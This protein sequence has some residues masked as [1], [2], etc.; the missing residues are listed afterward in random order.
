MT[1]WMPAEPGR[2]RSHW[3]SP[4]LRPS[5]STF[6]FRAPPRSAKNGE[7][8]LH[9]SSSLRREPAPLRLRIHD[10]PHREQFS[11]PLGPNFVLE[12]HPADPSRK[13]LCPRRSAGT[14]PFPEASAWSQGEQR[15]C[16]R[17]PPSPQ[18][19]GDKSSAPDHRQ[20]SQ[21]DRRA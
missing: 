15:V 1:A 9:A 12:I 18:W 6:S 14:L 21:G 20:V 2:E 13:V 3:A 17:S 16:P 10:C 5:R 7:K 11:C 8:A 4:Y 19:T